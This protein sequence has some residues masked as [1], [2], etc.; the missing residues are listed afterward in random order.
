MDTKEAGKKGGMINAQKGPEH[1]RNLQKLSV[2]RKRLRISVL[3]SVTVGELEN[4]IT[5]ETVTEKLE[6]IDNI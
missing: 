1:F 3:N 2:E 6:Q 4:P 5:A